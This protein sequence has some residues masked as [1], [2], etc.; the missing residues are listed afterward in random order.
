ML[1]MFR[2]PTSYSQYALLKKINRYFELSRQ[3]KISEE[4]HCHGLSILWLKRMAQGR[5]QEFY[6]NVKMIIDSSD[7]DLL[8]N[9]VAIEKF[10]RSFDKKQ[11][12]R[13]FYPNR[14]QS[15]VSDIIKANSQTILD[16]TYL[17]KRLGR[18]FNIHQ[19]DG[20]MFCI[21]NRKSYMVNGK[22][23][24]HS[25][26]VYV[27]DDQFYCYDSNFSTGIAKH[28]NKPMDVVNEI[29]SCLFTKFK[30][31]I[32]PYIPLEIKM[33]KS[34]DLKPKQEKTTWQFVNRSIS[35][36]V[37]TT[38]NLYYYYNPFGLYAAP[39]NASIKRTVGQAELAEKQQ[40]L[41][42]ARYS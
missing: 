24:R 36:A 1:S 18:L 23:G 3:D 32:P 5:E 20:N 33:I 37:T 22:M 17:K 28:F 11:N 8:V 19:Q 39:R 13:H 35:N 21:S 40:R 25:V 30:L 15:Q 29:R 34:N 6:N 38:K 4:G 16:A 7:Q 42:K 2:K 12:P 31:R 26:A 27:R 9:G 41:K 10:F 14:K